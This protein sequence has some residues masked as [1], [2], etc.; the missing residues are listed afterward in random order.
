MEN[1]GLVERLLGGDG[2]AFSVMVEKYQKVLYAVAFNVLGDFHKAQ[3]ITQEAFIKAYM[4]MSHLQSPERLGS[5]L[6]SITHRLSLNYL[7]NKNSVE[8]LEDYCHVADSFH[9]EEAVF[10]EIDGQNLRLALSTLEEINRSPILLHYFGGFTV[11][12]ISKILHASPDAI[13]SRIRRSRKQLKKQLLE[14]MGEDVEG[15]YTERGMRRLFVQLKEMLENEAFQASRRCL[16]V[17]LGMTAHGIPYYADLAEMSHLLVTGTKGSGKS[18]FLKSV[19]NSL[20]SGCSPDVLKLIIIDTKQVELS[21]YN[22]LPPLFGSV[23][24]EVQEARLALEHLVREMA[25]R[26]RAFEHAGV[27]HISQYNEMLPDRY[28]N[29]PKLP[30]IVLIIEEIADLIQNGVHVDDYV[31]ALATRSPAAGIHLI[32][33]TQTPSKA[34][35]SPIIKRN[36]TTKATFAVASASDAITISDEP[37]AEVLLG[38]GDMLFDSHDANRV[39][40]QSGYVSNVEIEE[41]VKKMNITYGK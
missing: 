25:S 8:P 39:R 11:I 17:P 33:S 4:S 10:R 24:S 22:Q 18:V 36:F 12:E 3:D 16:S 14:L 31:D 5:W 7:R 26:H 15:S 35:I 38:R 19:I 9:L 41:L 1:K 6:C 37:G 13:E 28:P 32:I 30:Y 40:L 20:L 34:V 29:A 27:E 21:L 23:I 2:E